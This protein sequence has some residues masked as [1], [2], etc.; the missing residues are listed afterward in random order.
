MN[1]NPQRPDLIMHEAFASTEIGTSVRK[2][3][4]FN[5]DGFAGM[6]L[7]EADLDMKRHVG[8]LIDPRTQLGDVFW[9]T[10]YSRFS[11][12]EAKCFSFRQW[13]VPGNVTVRTKNNCWS[14]AG[15][16]NRRLR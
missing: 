14:V 12:D 6:T 2:N 3:T 10:F 7:L 5:P 9:H 16:S 11:E 8:R 1:L 15:N 13:I 4:A